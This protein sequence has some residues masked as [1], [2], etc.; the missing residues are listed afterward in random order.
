[1]S[2]TDVVVHGVKK[3]IIDGRLAAGDRLPIEKDLAVELGVSRSSLREGVRALSVMGVLET[4]QGAGTYV[5]SLEPALLLAAMG[6]VVDLQN[7]KSA[8][9]LHSVRRI[10]ETEAAGL[11][12]RTMSASQ[13]Q[14]AEGWLDKSEAAMAAGP[15]D[16]EAILECDIQFHRLIA[17]CSGN[18]VLAA[19]I[20]ALA[21]QTVRGRL[22]RAISDDG[23]QHAALAEHR[24]ILKALRDGEPDKAR[25]RMA[26]HLLA[27]EEFLHDRPVLSGP[28]VSPL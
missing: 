4:R 21:S 14:A 11:A 23:A 18:P 28:A 2:Q 15:I 10:L 19:L 5:T 13:L 25:L 16:H 17:S 22:W 3:M 1:M 8:E 6:F 20:E 12:A 27:V 9:N 7:T 26:N 24:A